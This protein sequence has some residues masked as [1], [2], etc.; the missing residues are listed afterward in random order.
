[1]KIREHITYEVVISSISDD[2][3]KVTVKGNRAG[4]EVSFSADRV[5]C[6]FPAKV[7]NKIRIDPALDPAVQEAIQNIPY[8][9][10]TRT[11][12]QVDRAFRLDQ[13][14]SGMA[15]AG[16]P[17]GGVTGHTHVTEPAAH[18]AMLESY[19]SGNLAG[20]LAKLP[21]Q[22]VIQQTLEALGKV[23]PQVEDHFQKA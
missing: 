5:I 15:V 20:K 21:E 13:G 3:K 2:G 12:V 22:E 11:Y 18:S 1:E 23:H 7:V 17:I 16:L 19:T 6:T 4:E 8:L 10:I 9:D 14:I